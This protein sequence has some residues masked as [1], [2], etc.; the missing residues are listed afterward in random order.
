MS[1]PNIYLI[2]M[3]ASWKSTV[4][5][6]I[7]EKLDMEFVDTDDHIESEKIMSVGEIFKYMGEE[8]FRKFENATLKKMVHKTNTVVSTGGGIVVTDE[9][10]KILSDGFTILLRAKP[11]T[12][13]LRIKSVKK[14]PLLH[15]SGNIEDELRKIWGVRKSWY[16]SPS[17]YILDTD[18]MNPT[19]VTESLFQYLKGMYANH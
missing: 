1:Y 6:K 4:G 7:A 3:M 10:R 13:A 17:D 2:G 18:D 8:S 19:E 11:Q 12:L 14:R 15:N 16:E 9:N 5:K